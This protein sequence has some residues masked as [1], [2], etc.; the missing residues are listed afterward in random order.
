MSVSYSL[1]AD[2][3]QFILYLRDALV[4]LGNAVFHCLCSFRDLFA[5][6]VKCAVYLL[7]LFC[8]LG[9][10]VSLALRL[11]PN[12]ANVKRELS[13]QLI[14]CV[15]NGGNVK[16]L[17]IRVERGNFFAVIRILLSELV[18]EILFAVVLVMPNGDARVILPV[19]VQR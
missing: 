8:E 14:E 7:D 5:R 15:C 1:V 19:V 6:A 13:L 12:R 9:C 2:I 16:A 3:Q 4:K 10:V 18:R 17:I 11:R